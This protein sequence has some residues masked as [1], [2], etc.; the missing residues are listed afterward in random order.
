MDSVD[1]DF[2]QHWGKQ[3]WLAILVGAAQNAICFCVSFVFPYFTYMCC[4]CYTKSEEYLTS[5]WGTEINEKSQ[6][7]NI[8]I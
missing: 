7:P 4:S 6:T 1:K 8:T 3:M 2:W 5:K